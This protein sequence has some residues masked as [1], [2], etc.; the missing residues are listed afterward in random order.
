MGSNSEYC[1]SGGAD[2]RIH[3]W[4]I[5]DLNVDPYDGYGEDGSLLR[6]AAP[7]RVRWSLFVPSVPARA[8]QCGGEGEGSSV[9][10][11][12]GEPGATCSVC[13]GGRMG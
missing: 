9:R 7:L 4:K 2:A 10:P 1:Y 8:W 5:P 11:Q 6:P 3:S 13:D 12:P